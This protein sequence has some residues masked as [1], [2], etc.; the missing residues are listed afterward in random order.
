MTVFMDQNAPVLTI[1]GPSGSGKGTVSTLL[2]RELGWHFL[3]SGAL[4]RLTAL[5]ALSHGVS[6]DQESDVAVLAEH[7]DIRFDV[8]RGSVFLEGD[9]VTRELR[10]EKTGAA[11]SRVAAYP[12][13]RHALLARQRAFR[14]AP[15]LVADGR[16]MG[17]V[18]FPDAT[19][20]IFLT[21]SSEERARRRYEQ[22]RDS[23]VGT[24]YDEVLS[25]VIARDERDSSR[26][27]SPLIPA[28]DARLLD[29]THLSVDEVIDAIR[30]DLQK[31]KLIG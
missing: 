13:V 10:T 11:A 28:N 30:V 14:T 17:T 4:Y 27:A 8:E 6:L 25:E 29:S 16:D 18:V 24:S 9:D 22:L 5:C 23:G 1:D 15:G 7:L 20:K 12:A 31:L 3:D 21:A 26:A 2:A 19:L